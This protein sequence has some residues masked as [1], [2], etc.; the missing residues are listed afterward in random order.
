MVL[1]YIILYDIM[2]WGGDWQMIKYIAKLRLSK[3]KY[4][5]VLSNALV[6]VTEDE[7]GNPVRWNIFELGKQINSESLKEMEDQK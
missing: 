5:A 4:L 3:N 7:N 6:I 1:I 2:F